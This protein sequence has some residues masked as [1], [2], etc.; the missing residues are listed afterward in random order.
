MIAEKLPKVFG[1][2]NS[3][4]TA[5]YS[6]YWV[7]FPFFFNSSKS[8]DNYVMSRSDKLVLQD[9]FRPNS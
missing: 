7:D 3:P 1:F 9:E 5:A 8:Y 6:I 4:N 2:M